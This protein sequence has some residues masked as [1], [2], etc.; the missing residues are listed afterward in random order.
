MGWRLGRGLDLGLNYGW[1]RRWEAGLLAVLGF[2]RLGVWCVAL[3]LG[4][5]MRVGAR[6]CVPADLLRHSEECLSPRAQLL[7][8]GGTRAAAQ[9]AALAAA[10]A[11]AREG[12]SVP[13]VKVAGFGRN[14]RGAGGGG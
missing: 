1:E 4:D 7:Q 11:V 12:G 10:L 9:P 6:A 8:R 13:V 3:G 2:E 14:N 5:G